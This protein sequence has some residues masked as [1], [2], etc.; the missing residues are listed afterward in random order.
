MQ[1]LGIH[2]IDE[3]D[4][5]GK[6]VLLRVDINSPIDPTTK[7]ITNT[8]RIDKSI[9]TIEDLASSGAKVVLLAHQGDT[10]DYQNL[11]PL[12]EHASLEKSS[13]LMMWRA[14]LRWNW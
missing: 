1:A 8:N 9:P 11:I 2:T 14:Q 7:K 5:R 13:I 12:A 6:T 4:Y 3:F 10:L